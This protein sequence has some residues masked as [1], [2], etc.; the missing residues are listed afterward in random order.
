M[1]ETIRENNKYKNLVDGNWIASK[2]NDYIEIKSV[3][4]NSTVGFVSAMNQD[5]VDFV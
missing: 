5:E 3:L 1:F 4:D 2:T